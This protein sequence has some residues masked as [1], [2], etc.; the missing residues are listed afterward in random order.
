MVGDGMQC[1][2][3]PLL[4]DPSAALTPSIR[5]VAEAPIDILALEDPP[6]AVIPPPHVAPTD[7]GT[8]S[9]TTAAVSPAQ[10]GM[11]PCG[12]HPA[13]GDPVSHILGGRG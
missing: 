4:F 11:E 1:P 12:W 3:S 10:V 2:P 5:D 6:H 9:F 13:V 8:H 7:R